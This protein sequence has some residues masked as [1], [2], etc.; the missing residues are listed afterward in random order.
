MQHE[1]LGQSSSNMQFFAHSGREPNAT[2]VSSEAHGVVHDC[3]QIRSAAHTFV[4]PSLSV[5]Q[6]RLA[7][8]LCCVHR[9]AHELGIDPHRTQI[10]A[11]VHHGTHGAFGNAHSGS[12]QI[13]PIRGLLVGTH[14]SRPLQSALLEQIAPQRQSP[15]LTQSCD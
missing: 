10:C 6:Q 3:W 14:R 2:H 7:Q 8:S 15:S 4:A 9:S 13:P 1:V 12:A 11:F 5:M